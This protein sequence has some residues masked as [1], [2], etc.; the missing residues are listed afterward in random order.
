MDETHRFLRYVMPG[1]SF[2]IEALFLLLLLLPGWTMTRLGEL[3]KAGLGGALVAFLGLG[4]LGFLFSIVHH[5]FRECRVLGGVDNG[6]VIARLRAQNILEL[7][8]AGTGDP[9]PDAD[10]PDRH[11]AWV[12]V[13]ALWHQ[14]DSVNPRIKGANPRAQTLADLVHSIG[15]AQWGALFASFVPFVV[16]G[17]VAEQSSETNDILRFIAVVVLAAGFVCMHHLAYRRTSRTAEEMI[18]EILED[19]LTASFLESG[20]PLRTYV[21]LRGPG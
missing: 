12:I 21:A 20:V 6:P 15:T 3:A 9:V 5:L 10:R 18:A 8:H 2:S 17:F 1:A 19:T 4:G 7:L 11:Q 13:N 16:A 14:R